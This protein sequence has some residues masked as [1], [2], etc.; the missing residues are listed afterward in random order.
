[1]TVA[2]STD[3]SRIVVAGTGEEINVYVTQSGERVATFTGHQGGVYSVV[4]SPDGSQI[5]AAGFDGRVR[6]Y[7]LRTRALLKAFVPVPLQEL[8]KP[9]PRPGSARFQRPS[10]TSMRARKT[11]ALPGRGSDFIANWNRARH[12]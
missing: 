8:P 4:F 9:E 6:I 7:D 5:T 10:F 12:E 11:R 1:L 3:G 2:F